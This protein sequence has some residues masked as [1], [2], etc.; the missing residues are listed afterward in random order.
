MT[1]AGAV[2]PKPV[3]LPPPVR[4]RGLIYGSCA[5]TLLA[6]AATGGLHWPIALPLIATLVAG[7][8]LLPLRE[9]TLLAMAS[10]LFTSGLDFWG[11]LVGPLPRIW[12]MPDIPAAPLF[13]VTALFYVAAVHICMS[14]AR[15]A[16]ETR[17]AQAA[18]QAAERPPQRV[19]PL[20]DS[21][22]HPVAILDARGALT[23]ANAPYLALIDKPA[24]I[25]LGRTV[26]E[27]WPRRAAALYG[28]HL[29]QAASGQPVCF[30][31]P[32]TGPDN[33]KRELDVFLSPHATDQRA[34]RAMLTM[35]VDV[36]DAVRAKRGL[37]ERESMYKA[38][39]EHAPVGI[40]SQVD[41]L[42]I[43]ANPAALLML[44]ADWS[45]RAIGRPFA[46]F[47]IEKDREEVRRR[48]EQLSHAPGFAEFKPY[49]LVTLDDQTRDVELAAISVT[50][51]GKQRVELFCVDVTERKRTEGKI[52]QLNETLELR[53]A[54]RTA[55]LEAFTSSVSHDLRAPA[56]QIM[57]AADIMLRK[58]GQ[59]GSDL[60][61]MLSA[62][63]TT[64]ERMN[65]TI[66]ALLELSRLG[67]A[68]IV[69][70]L[71]PLGTMVQEIRSELTAGLGERWISWRIDNLPRIF[72]DPHLIRLVMVNLL[73][74]AVKF[75][76]YTPD[77]RIEVWA[78]EYEQTVA[79]NVRDNGA[80][81]DMRHAG[82]LF[83]MFSRLHSN[84]DFEG[85]GVGLA[86]CRR[87]IERHGGRIVAHGEPGKG[88]TVRFTLPHE[89]HRG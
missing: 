25:A 88:A 23:Y 13:A 22:P 45:G 41:G 63:L 3:S 64:A 73:D 67:R 33:A 18:R 60:K 32:F 53:V 5:G 29:E 89:P 1:D 62:L 4:G 43:Y 39:I 36:T 81:F 55:E 46:D 69:P 72:A 47:I 8:V 86:H 10:V 61:P 71:W 38:V 35:L 2:P 16:S 30:R 80:G 6:C 15:T 78:D 26:A 54:E 57:S 65:R 75:T 49:R 42:L 27:L 70:S 83:T 34:T 52:R 66:D 77:A 76:R 17:A 21:L 50:R 9:S 40:L 31:L 28:P 19:E 37:I 59:P 79:I 56:R 12:R 68:G 85:T 84:R 20:L 74:N 24:S 14:W 58:T 48:I 44:S 82:K 87:I 7:A 11:W 51:D